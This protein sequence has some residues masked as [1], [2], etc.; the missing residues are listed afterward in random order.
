MGDHEFGMIH[1]PIGKEYDIQIER[2]WS[3]RKTPFPAEV[4]F[5]SPQKT[6]QCPRFERCGNLDDRI[7][8]I[9]LL[10][11]SKGGISQDSSAADPPELR[12]APEIDPQM[13]HPPLRVSDISPHSDHHTVTESLFFG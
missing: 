5:D 9:V 10:R 6:Q 4:F 2:P 1:L 11:I 3:I 7:V 13:F 8:K 12:K